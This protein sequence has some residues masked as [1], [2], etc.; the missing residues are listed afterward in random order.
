MLL[1]FRRTARRRRRN[2]HNR[3]N[4]AG[5]G[6]VSPNAFIRIDRQGQVTLIIPQAEMGQGVYTSLSM[7]LAEELDVGFDR[8]AVEA[9]PP[10]D[11]LYANRFSASKSPAIRIPSARSGEAE[12]SGRRRPRH[13][14][15]SCGDAVER[16]CGQLHDDKGEV[17]HQAS[18]RR[19]GY[20]ALADAAAN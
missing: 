15:A 13:A 6:A 14:G 17:I 10:S 9:A 2:Q 5:E 12:A 3:G 8:V 18:G 7:I 11:A 4:A 19:L 20:G 1:G 16:R